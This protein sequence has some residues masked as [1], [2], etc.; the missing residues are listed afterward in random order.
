M[1]PRKLLFAAMKEITIHF[2]HTA[3]NCE[4]QEKK[5]DQQF[6]MSRNSSRIKASRKTQGRF[7]PSYK[8][9]DFVSGLS[10]LCRIFSKTTEFMGVGEFF[11]LAELSRARRARAAEHHG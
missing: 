2:L 10:E 5:I 11:F 6:V 7:L 1:Y 8:N 4:N 9:P 3:K